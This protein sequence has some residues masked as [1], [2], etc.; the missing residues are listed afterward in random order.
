MRSQ[1]KIPGG[2]LVAIEVWASGGAVSRAKITGDFFL[3]P[4][5][6]IERAEDSLVGIP[7]PAQETEVAGRLRAALGDAQLLGAS[8]EDFARLFMKAVG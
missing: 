8:P 5:E 4:E 6:A 2:K 1:E 7:L 3:H